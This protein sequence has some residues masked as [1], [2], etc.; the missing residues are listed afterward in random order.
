M[1][2]SYTPVMKVLHVCTKTAVPM[3]NIFDTYDKYFKKHGV[4]ADLSFDVKK[5]AKEDYDI[6]HGHYALTKPVIDAYRYAKRRSIPFVLHCHGSDVRAISSEG[7]SQ[8]PLKH[9][10]VSSHMR[11]RADRVLLSTPDLLQ[12]SRGNYMPNPVDIEMFKPMEIEKSERVLLLGRFTRGGG[13]MELIRP[14]KRYDCLNWGEQISFPKNV[15]ILPFVEHHELPEL[16]NRYRMMIGA[17]VDPVSLA[18]LEA[19]SCGLKTYTDFPE[20]FT[21]YYGLE[22]PDRVDDPRAFIERYHHPDKIVSVLVDMY[23]DLCQ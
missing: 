13:I 19:M 12:W 5:N 9:R 3:Q 7:Q 23:R 10:F 17:L 8:L 2:R 11:K 22:N 16:L 1:F 21:A 6:V 14:D 20:E 4:E 18:R 15:R